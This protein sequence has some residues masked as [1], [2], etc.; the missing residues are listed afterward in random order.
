MSSDHQRTEL[1]RARKALSL[2]RAQRERGDTA[3]QRIAARGPRSDDDRALPTSKKAAGANGK[4]RKVF[5][6]AEEDAVPEEEEAKADRR[7]IRAAK[8]AV[9]MPKY[10]KDAE[11]QENEEGDE[12]VIP[13]KHFDQPF[14]G[15]KQ[16]LKPQ[17]AQ[18]SSVPLGERPIKPAKA[19]KLPQDDGSENIEMAACSYCG[20]KFN[21]E[22]LAKHKKVCQERPDKVKRNVFSS[23]KARVVDAE[24]PTLQGKEPKPEKT[25]KKKKIPKWKIES[26][27]FRNAIKP[28]DKDGKSEDQPGA[29]APADYEKA[30][31]V[32]C[33]TCG[34][35]FNDDAAKRHMPFC[36]SKAKI[37]K[38]KN[39]QKFKSG[40]NLSRK[41]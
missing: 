22:S 28:Q 6:P 8:P 21:T 41:K 13:S 32:Q 39:P 38:M 36:A 23:S 1:A 3:L 27:R 25:D 5:K 26:A 20:R 19:A 18:K 2:L 29:L 17:Q 34:R 11:E 37:D 9:A 4:Y 14:G 35:S 40:S 7:P 16:P 15:D 31:Y 33:P 10:S 30:D 24:Q 12:P